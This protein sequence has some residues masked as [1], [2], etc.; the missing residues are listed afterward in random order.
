MVKTLKDITGPVEERCDV[1]V[2]G[3]GAGGAPMA[4]ELAKGGLSVVIL[5]EG[6]WYETK[7]YTLG[8]TAMLKKLYRNAGTGLI[9]GKPSIAF[10][11]GRAVGGSTVLNGGMCWRTPEKILEKWRWENGLTHMT[12]RDLDPVYSYVEQMASIKPQDPESIG[13]HSILFASAARRLGWEVRDNLRNQHHCAGANVCV[14]GCPTGAKRSTVYS[15]MPLA[16][17]NGAR[18][19]TNCRADKVI[20]KNG[21][22]VGVAG[23]FV[24]ELGKRHHPMTVMADHV[25]VAGGASET[26]ALLLRSGVKTQS[27]LLGENLQVHPNCKVIGLFD[28]EVRCWNGTHQAHQVKEFIDEGIIFASAA[29]GPQFVALGSPEYGRESADLMEKYNHMLVAGCLVEDSG[30]GRVKNGFGDQATMFYDINARDFYLL[31]RGVALMSKVIFEAG[32]R[33]VML[34]F[35]GLPALDSADEIPKIFDLPIAPT[36]TEIVTVHIMGTAQMGANPKRSVVDN[37][38]ELHDVK[39]LHVSDASLF[40]SP[41]GVN[42]QLT[43]MTLAVRNAHHLLQEFRRA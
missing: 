7:D 37:W 13:K 41:I 12:M 20:I 26:P 32:A 21:R 4:A 5:E 3:T 43:I 17:Q 9:M 36:D 8:T 22:A 24:D 11:E 38:G 42:P 27:K 29:I 35:A 19:Y 30:R 28:E 25:V 2:I 34:P 33:K 16:M 18:C 31:K 40:P 15:F 23:H 14:L 10:A 1:V 39:R 6:G